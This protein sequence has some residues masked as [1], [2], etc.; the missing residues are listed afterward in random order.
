MLLRAGKEGG[1]SA[2]RE[3]RRRCWVNLLKANIAGKE[4]PSPFRKVARDTVR[5]SGAKVR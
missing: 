5:A 4:T 3:R 1:G 2:G